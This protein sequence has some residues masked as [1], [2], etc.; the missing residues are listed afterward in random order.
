MSKFSK[1]DTDWGFVLVAALIILGC[2]LGY[3]ASG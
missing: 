3:M 2:A 1:P